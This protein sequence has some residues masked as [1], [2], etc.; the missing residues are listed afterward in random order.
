MERTSA[1]ISTRFQQWGRELIWRLSGSTKQRLV[2]QHTTFSV[3]LLLE[4]LRVHIRSAAIQT[5]YFTR[6]LLLIHRPT[7]DGF[8]E[9]AARSKQLDE[10][11]AKTCG[12]AKAQLIFY[13]DISAAAALGI[14]HSS[15]FGLEQQPSVRPGQWQ[16][17]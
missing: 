16:Y 10:A 13:P 9:C 7:A 12:I 1:R 5:H 17:C 15:L 14:N 11:T 3:D 6:V 4:V 2:S 8:Q